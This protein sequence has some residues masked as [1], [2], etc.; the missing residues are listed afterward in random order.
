MTPSPD[1][2]A[3][4]LAGWR[5]LAAWIAML[6]LSLGWWVLMLWCVVTGHDWVFVAANVAGVAG[7]VTWARA[8]RRATDVAE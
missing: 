5:L 1:P 2:A 8:G 6:A 3:R 4:P 7:L